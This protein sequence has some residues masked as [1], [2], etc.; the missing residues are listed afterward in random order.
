MLRGAQLVMRPTEI[1]GASHQIHPRVQSFQTLSGMTTLASRVTTMTI[2]SVG[3][4]SPSNMVPRRACAGPPTRA[5]T[6]P[7]TF[8]IMN[9]NVALSR[10]PSCA[11]RQIR[12]KL[13]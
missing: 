4:R 3:L 10:L 11:T 13:L 1:V 7:L 5:T 2:S 12:A 9:A 8:A 6:I